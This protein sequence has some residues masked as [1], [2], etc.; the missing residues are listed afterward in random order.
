MQGF[1]VRQNLLHKVQWFEDQGTGTSLKR[2]AFA[3]LQQAVF[4]GTVKTVVVWKLD[5]LPRRQHEGINRH[6]GVWNGSLPL[7]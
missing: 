7:F 6:E 2:P 3:R 5:R 1:S 4:A